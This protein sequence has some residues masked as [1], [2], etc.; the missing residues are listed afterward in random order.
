MSL[1]VVLLTLRG[2]L[3]PRTFTVSDTK[4]KSMSSISWTPAVAVTTENI[5]SSLVR[6]ANAPLSLYVCY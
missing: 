1:V 6:L 3:A 4:E 5:C 2:T